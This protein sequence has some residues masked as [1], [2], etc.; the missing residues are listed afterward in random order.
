ML[1]YFVRGDRS[2]E[3]SEGDWI[4]VCFAALAVL[5]D[6]L[7]GSAVAKVIKSCADVADAGGECLECFGGVCCVH[8]HDY[9]VWLGVFH[10]ERVV[11]V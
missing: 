11:L 1:F 8:G 3:F 10:P 9:V 2:R 4:G 7:C 6:K 5:G